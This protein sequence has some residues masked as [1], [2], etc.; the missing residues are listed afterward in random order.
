MHKC[1]FAPS[2]W[3]GSRELATQK[4]AKHDALV[5]HEPS[6]V[7]KIQHTPCVDKNVLGIIHCGIDAQSIDG[8]LPA[9][10]RLAFRTSLSEFQKLLDSAWCSSC[11]K[12]GIEKAVHTNSHNAFHECADRHNVCKKYL[13]AK[14][15]RDITWRCVMQNAQ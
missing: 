6:I 12:T 4:L 2:V 9:R 5:S 3:R 1:D 8:D 7:Q 10:N 15:T 13:E 14:T 11:G